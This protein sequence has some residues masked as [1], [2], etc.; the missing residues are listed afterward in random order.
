MFTALRVSPVGLVPGVGSVRPPRVRPAERLAGGPV[1]WSPLR[2]GGFAGLVGLAGRPG[3]GRWFRAP[4]ARPTGETGRE[5]CGLS[6][7]RSGGLFGV[8]RGARAWV[9]RSGC[10]SPRPFPAPWALAVR[11]VPGTWVSHSACVRV[12]RQAV[13]PGVGVANGE[14]AWGP[15]C[16]RRGCAW[17]GDSSAANCV[18]LLSLRWVCGPGRRAGQILGRSAACGVTPVR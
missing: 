15:L 13:N 3:A 18:V 12:A 16:R 2:G 6:P 14:P 5:P 11:P 7:L 1:G 8:G 10:V 9:K 17:P 4:A